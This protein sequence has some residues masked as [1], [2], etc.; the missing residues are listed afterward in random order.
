MCQFRHSFF[1][2]Y[3]KIIPS[4]LARCCVIYQKG[5]GQL[6]CLLWRIKKPIFSIGILSPYH[7]S[8]SKCIFP[9]LWRITFGGISKPCFISQTIKR[10]GYMLYAITACRIIPSILFFKWEVIL[11]GSNRLI[12]LILAFLIFF[13]TIKCPDP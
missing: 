3:V 7:W 4:C 8:T 10:K 11:G 1:F 6:S 5:Q 13:L 9:A 12:F 2:I